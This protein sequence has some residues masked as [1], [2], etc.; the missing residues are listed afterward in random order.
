MEYL[1][2]YINITGRFHRSAN[3]ARD[4]KDKSGL[5]EYIPTATAQEAAKKLIYGATASDDNHAWTITGPYGTGKTS[6]LLFITDLFCSQHP[7]HTQGRKLREDY[8]LHDV[9]YQ[10]I[11]SVG[12]RT[13][14]K[15]AILNDLSDQIDSVLP[16]LASEIRTAI[17]DGSIEDSAVLEFF[18]AASTQCK[19]AGLNGILLIIDEFGKFLEFAAQH[20]TTEDIYILQE[21][22]EMSSR[23]KGSFLFLTVLHSSIDGYLPIYDETRRIEWKKI[24]GRF[25]DIPFLEPPEQFLS[26]MG[27][28]IK[29]T[30]KEALVFSR[31]Q[32]EVQE[33]LNSKALSESSL[34]FPLGKLIP[35][36]VP[37]DPF[38]SLLLWPLFRSKLSQNE[39]SLFAFL[40][41]HGPFG[42]QEFLSISL[43][44]PNSP[45]FYRLDRLYDYVTNILGSGILL[46]EQTRRWAEIEHALD[47]IPSDAPILSKAIVKV[48][49]LLGMYGSIVGLAASKETIKIAVDDRYAVEETLEFLQRNSIVVFRK[50]IRAFAL[51]EGSD[52]DLDAY[53]NEALSYVG[54]G[55]LADRLKK[56]V[57]LRPFVARAHYIQKGTLRF[58]DVE[59]IDGDREQISEM[60]NNGWGSSDGKLIFVLSHDDAHRNE[61]IKLT[62]KL[63]S[64]MASS[65]LVFAFPKPLIGL[66]QSLVEVEAWTWIRENV[67]ALQGDPVAKK[68]VDIRI[69]NVL[70]GVTDKAGQVIGIRGYVFDPS[71]SD[72]VH[73]GDNLQITSAIRF[74]QWLSELCNDIYSKA[75][76]LHNELLNRENLSSAA[77]AARRNLIQAM[78]EAEEVDSLGI[79]GTPAEMSMYRSMV[80]EGGFHTYVNGS[81][82]L[83]AP[84]KTWKPVWDVMEAFLEGARD[85]RRPLFELI[86]IL[87]SPPFGVREG[88]V[89]VLIVAL[90]L[91]HKEYIAL[92][93]DGYFVSDLRVEV[94]ERLTRLPE[95]FELQLYQL[96]GRTRDAVSAL[97]YALDVLHL[98]G[99][100]D[101]PQL[102]NV[103]KPLVT[104]A[105]Q[106]PDFAKKTKRFE[107]PEPAKVRDVLLK[108]ADP[109]K[110]L[111]LELPA[112][113]EISLD[114]EQNIFQFVDSLRSS[115]LSLQ[116]AYPNLLDEIESELREVF[117]LSGTSSEAKQHLRKRAQP[118]V[119]WVVD[120]NLTPFVR[121]AASLQD[122]RDWREAL[123]RAIF[124]GRPP[125]TWLDSDVT[126][127]QILL[128]QVA[129]EFV[130]VEELVAERNGNSRS[131]I[132]RIGILDDAVT[133]RRAVVSVPLEDADEVQALVDK[134]YGILDEPSLGDGGK[135]LR[136]AALAKVVD[137][138]L[139][140]DVKDER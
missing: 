19:G 11:L 86:T 64:V 3:L 9:V 37:F 14:L 136:L 122:D 103:V 69:A 57:V 25:V 105:V 88:P 60:F 50:F 138:Y 107:S 85:Q 94:F 79:I 92:Y 67:Q 6:F 73:N 39:R 115:I 91:V 71:Q 52:V 27:T 123:A 8:S 10:P 26:L 81:W 58:F 137:G 1:R 46:G 51:W 77:T 49:G 15:M 35:A 97:S 59:I 54:H 130:R 131:T 140:G 33:F 139:N 72:W 76:E 61:H 83:V 118:L 2:K 125:F 74:Q 38:T 82:R 100:N 22:A 110:L 98:A 65:R 109:Y 62:Q 70:K 32:A 120:R 5:S 129:S 95:T 132:L 48:I 55:N 28:A 87:K 63:S 135:R 17:S 133:E 113:L 89:F 101:D 80:L 40:M 21:L 106:L 124:Q 42:F 119:E 126:K 93:E 117:G 44:D 111:F 56:A 104:F 29:W 128:R 34:R 66:E 4:W 43:A 116:S 13:S 41:D 30:D 114:S 45:K 102:L 12:H 127:Y 99:S 24:Q 84:K 7:K 16:A 23:G 108:T 75:P 78:V 68:E 112:A 96:S 18:E 53:Y 121:A 36:S 47:R 90:I 31:Y 20:P 134:I